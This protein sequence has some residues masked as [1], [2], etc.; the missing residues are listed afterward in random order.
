MSELPE[1]PARSIA[2]IRLSDLFNDDGCPLCRQTTRSAATY[3]KS[4]LYEGVTDV[5]FRRELDRAR[6]FCRRHTRD[7]LATNRSQSGGTLGSAILFGAILAI[8]GPEADA[9][10]ASHGSGRRKRLAEAAR[11]AACPVCVVEATAV[12]SAIDSFHGLASFPEWQD[13]IARAQ[14]CLDHLLA[15]LVHRPRGHAWD[16]IEQAQAVRIRDLRERLDRFARSSSHDRR[17][18]ITADEQHA[19]D[20][21]AGLLG[22][23]PSDPSR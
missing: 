12:A 18:Q 14:F 22:G 10:L 9:A 5:T 4:F 15:L 3:V 2:D 7:V 16:Q 21:A 19:A 1:L 20:D 11:P 13:A 17:D 8:R 23:D 6:G